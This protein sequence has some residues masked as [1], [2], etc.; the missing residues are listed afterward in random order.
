MITEPYKLPDPAFQSH[1][2]NPT[3][4]DFIVGDI[5]GQYDLL[6][7]LLSTTQFNSDQDR[8]FSVGDLVDRGDQSAQALDFLVQPW[9]FA[10]RGNHEDMLLHAAAHEHDF[11]YQQWW[12]NA[13]GGWWADTQP[14]V[15]QQLHDAI[16]QLPIG[17]QIDT[18]PHPIAIIHA[19]CAFNWEG[20]SRQLIAG[21]TLTVEHALWSRNRIQLEDSSGVD[22]ANLVF[23]G[24][25]PVKQ[26]LA[27]GNCWFIDT[28]AFLPDGQLTLAE[29]SHDGQC[30]VKFHQQ[31]H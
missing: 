26:P 17:R 21:N 3:G 19:D 30:V 4:R 1:P 12:Q 29:L 15:R 20:F 16:S 14:A 8:L 18:K 28:G 31:G 5:H 11:A 9:F 24:H 25:T 23:I 7:S 6:R 2:S 13:G 10:I 22:A 27:L